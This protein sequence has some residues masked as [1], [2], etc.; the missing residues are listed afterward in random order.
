M[1]KAHQGALQVEKQLERP[2][3]G[4]FPSNASASTSIVTRPWSTI[5]GINKPPTTLLPSHIIDG[6]CCF[7]YDEPRHRQADCW[8][9]NSKGLL[10]EC[11]YN[12][13]SDVN[14]GFVFYVKVEEELSKE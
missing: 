9:S 1:P 10:V 8:K 7:N 3:S 13:E 4:G 12:F 5:T 6:L 14:Y 11:P 2:N